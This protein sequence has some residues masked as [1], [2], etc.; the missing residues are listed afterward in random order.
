MT[1]IL[2][3]I[4]TTSVTNEGSDENTLHDYRADLNA[5]SD[6]SDNHWYTLLDPMFES[7]MPS[8]FVWLDMWSSNETKE[9]DSEIWNSTDLPERAAE[10]ATCGAVE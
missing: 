9:S 8:D 6:F 10:M 3:L 5:I 7:E 4:H 2:L 1:Q